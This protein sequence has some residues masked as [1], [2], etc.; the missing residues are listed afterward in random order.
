MKINE[1]AS[2]ISTILL[3]STLTAC[4]SSSEQVTGITGTA[5]TSSG[6]ITEFGSIYV[7][8]VHYQTTSAKLISTDDNKTLLTN[9]T[10]A[11]LQARIGLGQIVT[12]KG[13]LSDDSNGIANTISFDNE[14]AGAVTSVSVNEA[15]FVILGQT[16]SITPDTIIDDTLIEA[17]RG[18]EIPDD[19]K[20]SDLL[21]SDTLDL[22]LPT[23]T[24]V[25]VSGFPSQNGFEA[26]RIEDATH[27]SG[28]TLNFESE[29]KG[30]VK[31]LTANQFELNAL[32]ILYDSSA[33]DIDDFR[34]SNLEEG[35]F[36]EVHGS[37]SSPTLMTASRIER[38]DRLLDDDFNEG[39]LELE[40]VVQKITADNTGAGGIVTI[41]GFDIHV[42]NIAQF[43]EGLRIEIK[44]QLLSDGS[45]SIHRIKDEQE[46]SVRIEDIA[47]SADS[48]GFTTRL[49]LVISPTDRSRLEDDSSNSGDAPSIADFLSKVTD[50]RIEARGFSLNSNNVWTRIEIEKD[51]EMDCRLRGM[52]E[53]GSIN[54]DASSFTFSI[55]GVTINVSNVSSNN[56]KDGNDLSIDK[57]TFFAQLDEGD[58]VQAQS[59][60]AGTGCSQGE[61][62]ARE[63]EL[64]PDHSVML[65]TSDASSD[66]SAN[67]PA[68]NA[69]N[70][71]FQ[72]IGSVSNINAN[73]FDLAGE[74][75]T[76][77]DETIIDDSIIEDARGFEV[78]S[79]AA[80]GDIPETLDQLLTVGM[81]LEVMVNRSSGVVAISIED[82]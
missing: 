9:P 48:T 37:A 60:K 25:V 24:L 61:L 71:L 62:A 72:L 19:I 44:G 51:S 82:L 41:N 3:A 15:S 70:N 77:V 27:L 17:L 79:E 20:F 43:V 45:V 40:G 30:T 81:G 33:L 2:T 16:I 36:V 63:V 4:G 65:S 32:T 39:E 67:N 28:G 34:N 18:S 29:V 12:V 38:E 52:V 75:I 22:L 69:G 42:D 58:I 68:S 6:S 53:P 13:T 47:I 35:M 50:N 73:S 56:F 74:T 11:E 78:D 14:L 80:F 54:G 8:G 49:G 64:E 31:N 59:D 21:N 7:N 66:N 23:G 46:D 55:E 57:A 76:V 5:V 26:T 1:L 10:N